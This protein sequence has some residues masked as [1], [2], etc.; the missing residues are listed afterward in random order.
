MMATRGVPGLAVAPAGRARLGHRPSSASSSGSGAG[1]RAPTT[2]SSRSPVPRPCS[3]LTGYGIAEAERDELP[4]GRLPVGVVD[5]VDHEA[6]RRT[7]P[8]DHLGRG[9][10]LVGHPDG[11]V[12]DHQDDVGLG[13]GALG[14]LAHLGVERVAR[15]QPPAGVHD[16]ERHAGPLGREHLAV[17]GHPCLLLDDGGP[18]PRRCGSPG[19]TSR[20]W[21]D[22]P[23]R[24]SGGSCSRTAGPERRAVERPRRSEAPVAS[25]PPR[26]A[27]GRS[28]RV[29]PSRK[30][31]SL[32][33]AS[34]SR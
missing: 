32:R 23:R 5:L 15:G 22:R 13:Q 31:P 11:H 27:V 3:A 20:R 10:V 24:P 17:P 29:I 26:P 21:G 33:Q 25:A 8:P 6:H 28:A 18:R 14:L 4:D 34:G 9:Q 12:D 7:G 1:Q 19:R 2:S 30:R 16:G